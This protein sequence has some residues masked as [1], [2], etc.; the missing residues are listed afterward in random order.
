MD[1][2]TIIILYGDHGMTIEGNHGGDSENEIRTVFFAY[3][4]S[5]FP[6]LQQS[7]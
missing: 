6:M 3:T 1:N 5:G 2:D 7:K 4:K